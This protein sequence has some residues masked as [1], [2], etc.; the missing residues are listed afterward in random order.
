M[1][2]YN[3][4]AIL[5]V[6]VNAVLRVNVYLFYY[7]RFRYRPPIEFAYDRYIPE[8]VVLG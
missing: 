8:L 5:P 4:C 3:Y 7:I 2:V 1:N 6:Y